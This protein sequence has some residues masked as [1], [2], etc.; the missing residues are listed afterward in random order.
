MKTRTNISIRQETLKILDAISRVSG[1]SKSEIL[2]E[3]FL[4]ASEQ[5]KVRF[6]NYIYL[7][8]KEK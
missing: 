2:E 8:R 6:P 7:Y 3:A 4:N 1:K 5:L